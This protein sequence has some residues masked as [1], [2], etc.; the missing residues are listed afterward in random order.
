M[1]VPPPLQG[2]VTSAFAQV[3]TEIE[4]RSRFAPP[5]II[6]TEEL[7]KPGPPS[8]VT[9]VFQPTI[10]LRGPG[11]GEQIVAPAGA[12]SATGWQIPVI[13]VVLSALVGLTVVLSAAFA[14]GGRRA[15]RF[16]PGP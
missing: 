7:L 10:I 4:V 1:P 13:V 8:S 2:F 11:I 16:L 12:V 9:R 6:K 5:T 15:R 3:V 14:A